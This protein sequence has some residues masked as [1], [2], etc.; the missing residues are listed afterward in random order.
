MIS[1]VIGKTILSP[2]LTEFARP[3]SQ[4]RRPALIGKVGLARPIGP[5]I[6]SHH[7]PSAVELV[8]SRRV[9]TEGT[10]LKSRFLALAPDEFAAPDERVVYGAPQRLPA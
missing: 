4:D 3:V 7:E 5:V 10:L 6:A 1:G 8:L 2:N 9:H